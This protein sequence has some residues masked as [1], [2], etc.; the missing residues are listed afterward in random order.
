MKEV[1]P[2]PLSDVLGDLR[3]TGLSYGYCRMRAPWG[4]GFAK[5]YSTRLHVVIQGEAW[6]RS[7]RFGP[8]RLKRGDIALI[9]VGDAHALASSSTGETLPLSD[10]D[11]RPIGDRVYRI[12]NAANDEQASVLA[13]C[14]ISF[15]KSAIHPILEMIP[16]ILHIERAAGDDPLIS[17]LLD[18]MSA[19]VLNPRLGSSTVLT[20]LGDLA[21]IRLIRGWVEQCGDREQPAAGWLAALRDPKIGR[22]LGMM[23]RHPE[24]DW[25]VETLARSA[26]LSRSMFAARF[27]ELMGVP[28][29][30]YL[31]KQRMHI[32]SDWMR[33]E[34]LTV[35]EAAARA[36]YESE[37][38]FSRAFKRHMGVPPRVLRQSGQLLPSLL[39]IEHEDAVGT[40]AR[41]QVDQGQ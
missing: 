1:Q 28:P 15:G 26:R 19:E 8:V 27:S 37:P 31:T 10:Y 30:R 21:V 12:E 2:D 18:A 20:R 36:G 35:A 38:S 40:A 23:H 14:N 13:C 29:L 41:V 9:P 25:T 32:A 16:P 5:E 17:S 22:A 33:R 34:R 24:Q 4:I 11:A 7:D 3:P 6:V 39:E